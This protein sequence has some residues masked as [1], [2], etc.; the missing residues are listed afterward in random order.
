MNLQ[1]SAEIRADIT[2]VWATLMDV[3]RWSE[4]T[5]TFDSLERLDTGAFGIGSRARIRQ[6]RIPVAIWT[7]TEFEPGRSFTWISEAIGIKSVATHRL[8]P[9]G[10][11]TVT[12]T[13][14]LV[15]TGW[16]AWLVRSRA[17]KTAREYLAIEAQGLK[18]R[19]EG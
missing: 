14:G 8:E 3:E 12:L 17:E 15:Q 7:V 1:Q 6:P 18:R 9:R 13:L 19:C 5:R 16:L 2:S 4:W 11:G 10:D